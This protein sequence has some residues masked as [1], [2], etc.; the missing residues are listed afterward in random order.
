MTGFLRALRGEFYALLKRRQMKLA[1]LVVVAG[2]VLRLLWAHFQIGS[3]LGGPLDETLIARR[4]NF[5]PRFAQAAGVG[6]ILTELL[7]LVTL[8]A[9]LPREIGRGAARDPLVRRISRPAFLLARAVTA[10]LF[11]LVLGA[12]SLVSAA[13]VGLVL[14]PPGNVTAPPVVIDEDPAT[15]AAYQEWL[16]EKGVSENDL[17]AWLRFRDDGL[18]EGLPG[19]EAARAASR[20]LEMPP[21]RIPEAFESYIPLL[22]FFEA[23]IRGG[24]LDAIRDCV[25]PL[26]IL[27]LFSFC[28]SVIFP[29]SALSAGVALGSVLFFGVFLAR[30]LG[31][32]AWWFF[33][34]WLPGMGSDSQ[35][36][37]ARKVADGYGEPLTSPEALRTGIF[38]SF[39]EGAGF[40]ILS[41]LVF[42]RRRL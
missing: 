33:P 31:D 25:L 22:I 20:R 37:L 39:A 41:L 27:G 10:M 23:E 5:W 13:A 12:A 21:F 3:A 9:A 28:V 17:A 35:L 24:I 11:P 7:T 18:E 8:G 4:S 16:A 14:F 40:L 29:S 6:M 15:R 38:G 30:E 19:E 32:A 36:E 1:L 34:D 2:V 42:R 26:L